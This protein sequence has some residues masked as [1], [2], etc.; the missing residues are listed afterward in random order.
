M[1]FK[2]R[3]PFFLVWNASTNETKH[4]HKTVGE[5]EK[6]AQRLSEEFPGFKFHVLM[7]LGRCYTKKEVEQS[8]KEA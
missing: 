2:Q 1:A 8:A 3:P 4:R 6:E 7:A 5:A